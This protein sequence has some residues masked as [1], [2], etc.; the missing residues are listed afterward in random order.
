MLPRFR[1]PA[2]TNGLLPL[3]AQSF[4]SSSSFFFSTFTFFRVDL[5]REM[6]S[7][8]FFLALFGGV[9]QLLLCVLSPVWDFDQ[10]LYGI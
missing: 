1:V 5:Q 10:I 8:S 9:L 4:F 2:S 6:F 7:C 3:L